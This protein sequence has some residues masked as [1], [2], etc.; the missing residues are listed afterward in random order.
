MN[1]LIS[2]LWYKRKACAGVQALCLIKE[3]GAGR[4]KTKGFLEEG[5]K[6]DSNSLPTYKGTLKENAQ[7]GALLSCF[8]C[9]V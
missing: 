5:V 3:R 2:L 1:T 9:G 6:E 8:L 7:M 4:C